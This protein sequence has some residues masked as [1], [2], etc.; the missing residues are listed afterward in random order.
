MGLA[1]SNRDPLAEFSEHL[2]QALLGAQLAASRVQAH[3]DL[4]LPDGA[5]VQVKYLANPADGW[6]AH[7][8]ARRDPRGAGQVE[9]AGRG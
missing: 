3:W 2:V 4:A 8:A 9:P 5:K 6:V 1:V 7:R